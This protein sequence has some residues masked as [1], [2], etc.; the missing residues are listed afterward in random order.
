MHDIVGPS[1]VRIDFVNVFVEET[2]KA[3]YMTVSDSGA[4]VQLMT[5]I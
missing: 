4:P 3:L 2:A 1:T 5:S